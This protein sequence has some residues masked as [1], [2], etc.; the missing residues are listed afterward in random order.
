MGFYV[1][2]MVLIV[3]IITTFYDITAMV[4]DRV[5]Q[6]ADIFGAMLPVFLAL[7]ASS[8]NLTQTALMLS[9]IHILPQFDDAGKYVFGRS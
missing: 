6:T 1:C 5:E 8:G 3:V 2:Y 4:V 7:A 9:L